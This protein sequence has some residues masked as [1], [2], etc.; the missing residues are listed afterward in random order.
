MK[1]KRELRGIHFC[2]EILE[3]RVNTAD[4]TAGN[5]SP[6]EKAT[7]TIIKSRV[8]VLYHLQYFRIQSDKACSIFL[9]P[10]GETRLN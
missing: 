2:H 10:T 5:L 4:S 9:I 3:N 7:D 1:V 8:I 6:L